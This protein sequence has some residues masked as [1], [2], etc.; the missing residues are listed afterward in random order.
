MKGKVESIIVEKD[1]R[2]VIIASFFREGERRPRL[3]YSVTPRS[4]KRIALYI[5][6][7]IGSFRMIPIFQV[8]CVGWLAEKT[9]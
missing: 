9:R 4:A 1:R 7:N 6:D 8:G 5:W 3:H 2:G